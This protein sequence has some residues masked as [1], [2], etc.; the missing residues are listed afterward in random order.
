[1][2]KKNEN[3]LKHENLP[4]KHPVQEFGPPGRLKMRVVGF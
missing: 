4:I 1:M 2:K 3:V